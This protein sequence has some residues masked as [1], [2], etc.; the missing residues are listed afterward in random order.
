MLPDYFVDTWLL[1]ASNNR[2]DAYHHRAVRLARAIQ[3]SHLITHD[4]ILTELLAYFS[5]QGARLRAQAVEIARRSLREYDVVHVDQ[6]LFRSAL[7]L[8]AA[9]PDKEYSL[10]DC[11]SMT[12]MRERGIRHVLTNDHHFRQEGFEVVSE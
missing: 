1:I 3:P 7:D 5:A 12:L 11:I 8:Y 10:V 9:R 2:F 4:A 6:L